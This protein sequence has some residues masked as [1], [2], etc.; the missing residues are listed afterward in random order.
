VRPDHLYA[1]TRLEN[2]RDML[3]RGRRKPEMG[4][5]GAPSEGGGGWV[6]RRT[7]SVGGAYHFRVQMHR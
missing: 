4:A 3:A 5:P 2:V 6:E 7:R 1:G